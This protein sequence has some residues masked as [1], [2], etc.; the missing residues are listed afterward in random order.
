MPLRKSRLTRTEEAQ[1]RSRLSYLKQ[2]GIK[3]GSGGDHSAPE[4][5]RFSLEQIDPAFARVHEL[6]AGEVAE[7]A[8]V[9]PAKFTVRKSGVMITESY[10]IPSWIDLEID[11]DNVEDNEAIINEITQGLPIFPP[12][13]LNHEFVGRTLPLRPCQIE[14]VIIGNGYCPVPTKF[15]DETIVTLKLVLVDERD[16][17]FSFDFT[18][19]IDRSVMR[20]HRRKWASKHPVNSSR[21]SGLFDTIEPDDQVGISREVQV[22]SARQN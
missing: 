15:H 5:G 7:I 20:S 3:V 22:K 8:V 13:I 11:L 17:V 18:A 10:L 6:A 14:G 9:L 12:R 4:S 19:G 16:G 21:R 2:I 1:F